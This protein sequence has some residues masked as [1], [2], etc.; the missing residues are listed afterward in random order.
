MRNCLDTAPKKLPI[1]KSEGA[2]LCWLIRILISAPAGAGKTTLLA[3]LP[4]AFPETIWSWLLLDAEDNDPSRF[5]AA[6]VASLTNAGAHWDAA[7][8]EIEA[9][10]PEYAR[11]GFVLTLQ[12]WISELPEEARLRR[13]RV[14][15]LLAHA[16][17]TQNEFSQA[18]PYLEQ[19]LEGFRRNKDIVGQG[20]T[21]VALA[22]SAVMNN[23]FKE[24]RE[25]I[26]RRSHSTS[27][28]PIVCSFIRPPPGTLYTAR[29][30][31]KL[32]SI[33]TR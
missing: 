30:G 19:A 3:D 13:P 33:S 27:R 12:R 8:A 1:F 25:M 9:I 17:W 26:A 23:R 18:Q 10:G 2:F 32:S 31:L 6:L 4:H 28:T 7:A 24:S 21:L 14:L 5:A 15:Y 20:D 16:I 22:N 11:R 29:I